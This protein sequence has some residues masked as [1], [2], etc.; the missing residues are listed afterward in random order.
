MDENSIVD[1]LKA[2]GVPSDMASRRIIAEKHGISPY[3]GTADQNIKLLALLRNPP[4]TFWDDVKSLF[5]G[6]IP[7]ELK[8]WKSPGPVQGEDYPRFVNRVIGSLPPKV[9]E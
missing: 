7:K 9:G 4:A 8:D 5:N 2:Q 6:L 3:S 1:Y